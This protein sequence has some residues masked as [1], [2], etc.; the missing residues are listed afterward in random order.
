MLVEKTAAFRRRRAADN[1]SLARAAPSW[2]RGPETFSIKLR[3]GLACPGDFIGVPAGC[4]FIGI[5][6]R[7]GAGG[8]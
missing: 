5:R 4:D 8:Q 2:V 3:L 7:A 1:C 6:A